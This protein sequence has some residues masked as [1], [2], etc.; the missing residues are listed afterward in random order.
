[1]PAWRI[2]DRWIFKDYIDLRETDSPRL[3]VLRKY[4]VDWALLKRDAVLANNLG[5]LSGWRKEYED[6]KVVIYALERADGSR[7]PDQSPTPDGETR[8]ESL[9]SM[10]RS[11]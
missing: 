7:P 9:R 8:E 6:T 5:A 11:E 3:E 10:R 2:G 1:M 4:S